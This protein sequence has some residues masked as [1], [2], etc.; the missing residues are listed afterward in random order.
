VPNLNTLLIKSN[1][2]PGLDT[3]DWRRVRSKA[4]EANAMIN[5]RSA[6]MRTDKESDGTQIA[7]RK[8]P[9]RLCLSTPSTPRES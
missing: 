8:K 9:A 7:I 1:L 4:N 6:V 3:L 5:S 2:N